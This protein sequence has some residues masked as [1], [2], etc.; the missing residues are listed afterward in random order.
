[1]FRTRPSI[2]RNSWRWSASVK[3]WSQI[4]LATIKHGG[5]AGRPKGASYWTDEKLATDDRYPL[6]GAMRARIHPD[7]EPRLNKRRMPIAGAS[8]KA[9][10][11][12]VRAQIVSP[13]LC[14]D[15]LNYAGH[16]LDK[17]KG[18][19][20]LDINPGAGL[21]SRKLHDYLQPRSHV[22]LE[23]R[24]DKFDE[25]LRP[26]LDAPG[27]KYK[28]VD[29]DPTALQTYR[30]MITDGIFPNQTVLDPEDPKAQEPNNS[31]LVTGSLVWDPRLPG[32][33]FDSMA[34]QL[35]M[36]FATAIWSNDLFHAFGLVRTLLWVQ[37]DD[38]SSTIAESVSNMHKANRLLEL[39]QNINI[40]V[41]ATRTARKLGKGSTGREPQYEIESTVRALQAGRERGM[42][43][44]LHRRDYIHAFAAH[45]EEA[46]NGTGI[47][48]SEQI[49]TYLKD[50]HQEGLMGT[51]L[52]QEGFMDYYEQVQA[53]E[54][55]YPDINFDLL[56]S[57]DGIRRKKQVSITGHPGEKELAKIVKSSA[58][59]YAGRRIKVAVE[60][61]ADIGEAMYVLECKILGMKDGPEKDA[62]MAELEKL[63]ANWEQGMEGLASNYYKAPT[64]EVDERL[65]IRAPPSP[66]I[67]WDSR[68]F[69]PLTM[70]AN[71]AWPQCQLCL[72]SAEPIPKQPGQ[73]LDYP[74][75]VHD[76]VFGL[77]SQPSES[78]N[79]ALDKMQHGLSD[80]IDDCPSLKDPSKGGRLQM[81]HLRV[82]MLTKEMVHELIQA[83]QNWPFK[84]PG[85]DNNKFFR[86]RTGQ[87]FGAQDKPSGLR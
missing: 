22:L 44:P 84:A 74:E 15:V 29:K 18:C 78:I 73:T 59:I 67:Q 40:I 31:L 26:L 80:I 3:P 62:A 53:L 37:Q 35:F 4:R 33:G 68:P 48:S 21:W 60:K 79:E 46:S 77:Y 57:K 1:M 63:N 17:H 11:V 49:Q 10:G 41:K 83:Y 47:S 39:T 69:E 52:L 2:P 28:L 43:L 87:S 5:K 16:S 27:S 42:E 8:A 75:W 34:K 66:R 12:H 30:D 64:S 24:L 25:F 36:H 56:I 76:F 72:I 51:G 45:V 54:K 61:I 23:P 7:L 32:M 13:D 55:K 71:E 58:N 38:F 19:D 70:R 81:N 9:G 86:N 65:A 6:S 85:S 82:R 14:D 50:R 20:I